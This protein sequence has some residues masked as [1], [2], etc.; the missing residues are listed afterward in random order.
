MKPKKYSTKQHL[1]IQHK[2]KKLICRVLK[3]VRKYCLVTTHQNR[4]VTRQNLLSGP[5]LFD[6]KITIN[7]KQIAIVVQLRFRCAVKRL[8]RT[9]VHS[10]SIVSFVFQWC[11]EYFSKA[12]CLRHRRSFNAE[13]SPRLQPGV[14]P[15]GRSR[16][17]CAPR[18]SAAP[19]RPPVRGPP[20]P[21]TRPGQIRSRATAARRSLID[22][23]EYCP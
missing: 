4:A 17:T 23:F 22:D 10:F 19:G 1:K 6:F 14:L 16:P 3:N 20:P 9:T 5:I 11:H 8:Q 21:S 18:P 12:Y 7:Y 15:A 2:I 13:T